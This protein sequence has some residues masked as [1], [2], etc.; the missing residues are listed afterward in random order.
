MLSVEVALKKP[1][2]KLMAFADLGFDVFM[3]EPAAPKLSLSSTRDIHPHNQPGLSSVNFISETVFLS[4]H[5]QVP[6]KI[7]PLD[8]FYG[9]ELGLVR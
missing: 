5:T 3:Q 9:L 2:L 8:G 1:S 7:K 6:E 4:V